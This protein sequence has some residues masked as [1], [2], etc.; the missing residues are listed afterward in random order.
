MVSRGLNRKDM[1][2]TKDMKCSASTTAID[3]RG[4]EGKMIERLL[5]SEVG[6]RSSS[7]ELFQS[8]VV[9]V[10]SG[11]PGCGRLSAPFMSFVPFMLFQFR[12]LERLPSIG[13]LTGERHDAT[14]TTS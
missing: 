6:A 4:P 8:L 7:Q 12:L 13:A 1:K 14:S 9:V 2:G 5:E 3:A 11:A 10:R